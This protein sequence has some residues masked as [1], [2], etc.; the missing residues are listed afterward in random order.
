VY[1]S[2]SLQRFSSVFASA[3]QSPGAYVA[4]EVVGMVVVVVAVTVVSVVVDVVVV[5]V[6]VTVGIV[7]VVVVAVVVVAVTVVAVVM[8]VVVVVSWPPPQAQH[9]YRAVIPPKPKA[10]AMTVDPLTLL[11]PQKPAMS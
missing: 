2:Q 7:V 6:V 1:A 3:R 8:V 11:A 5:V 10:S 4:C 9:A